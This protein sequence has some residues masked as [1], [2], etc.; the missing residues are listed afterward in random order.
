MPAARKIIT[1]EDLVGSKV[2]TAE[3]NQVGRVTEIQVTPGPEY[4]VIRFDIGLSAWL[5]RLNLLGRLVA[6]RGKEIKPRAAY[7]DDVDRYEHFTVTL[8]PG[9]A[10]KESRTPAE[11]K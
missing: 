9:C 4:R 7:W 10:L 11:R 1:I 5:D 6:V 2:V 8:K 3:G